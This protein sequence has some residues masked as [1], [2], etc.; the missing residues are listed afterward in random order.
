MIDYVLNP[1]NLKI[2]I[3]QLI[4]EFSKVVDVRLWQPCQMGCSDSEPEDHNQAKI[5]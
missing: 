1:K 3:V 4:I 2:K 5:P